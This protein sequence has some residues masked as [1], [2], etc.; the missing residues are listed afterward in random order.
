MSEDAPALA[1]MLKIILSPEEGTDVEISAA[2]FS[3]R[4]AH[5]AKP[6]LYFSDLAAPTLQSLLRRGG[7]SNGA[8][9]LAFRVG[10]AFG[11]GPRW[12]WLR[13]D[14]DAIRVW[15]RPAGDGGPPPEAQDD[16]PAPLPLP[17]RQVATL[18]LA[19]DCPHCKVASTA[20]RYVGSAFICR[21]CGRSFVPDP[22]LLA[23]AHLVDESGQSGP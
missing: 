12:L 14:D 7:V 6:S 15:V 16:L 19:M 21:K 22:K 13:A 2:G 9:S 1:K 10:G 11:D 20:W 23:D 3:V 18:P 8:K 5:C 17:L 4:F